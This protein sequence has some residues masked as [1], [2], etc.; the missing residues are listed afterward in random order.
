[1]LGVN[2]YAQFGFG[3]EGGVTFAKM[4]ITADDADID[5]KTKMRTSFTLGGFAT[6]EILEYLDLSAGLIYSGRGTNFD[7]PAAA[8]DMY[9]KMAYLNIPIH[10]VYKYGIGYNDHFARIFAGPYIGYALSAKASDGVGL[11]SI[12]RFDF[13]LDLGA[14]YQYGKFLGNIMYSW[15]LANLAAEGE[16]K[17]KNQVLTIS[18]GYIISSPM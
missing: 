1:M 12:G 5:L 9:I 4:N 7:L 10:A 17:S 18:V 14:G 11:S 6:Y 3:A 13:G 15:G 2:A 8:G 16:G